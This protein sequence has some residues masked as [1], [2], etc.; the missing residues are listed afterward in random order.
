MRK[1]YKTLLFFICFLTLSKLHGQITNC[2]STYIIRLHFTYLNMDISSEKFIK[3]G[4]CTFFE[5]RWKSHDST[6]YYFSNNIGHS[7]FIFADKKNRIIEEGFWLGEFFTGLYIS[8]YK[9]GK[10]Q[11][12]GQYDGID[13]IGVWEYFDEKGNLIKTENYR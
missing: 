10:V 6:S 8:Y 2:D 5:K 1:L 12:K 7:Y 4:N 11:S 3:K 13:K 9:N